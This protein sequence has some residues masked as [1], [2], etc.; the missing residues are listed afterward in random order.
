MLAHSHRC[1]WSMILS[2]TLLPAQHRHCRWSMV[3]AI[4]HWAFSPI[5]VAS[6]IFELLAFLINP[7]LTW[8]VFNYPILERTH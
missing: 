8:G 1:R 5:E 4:I 7:Y 3:S 6:A 2:T